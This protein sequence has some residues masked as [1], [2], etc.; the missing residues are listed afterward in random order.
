MLKSPMMDIDELTRV[1]AACRNV[2]AVAIGDHAIFT[3]CAAQGFQRVSAPSRPV[4]PYLFHG[5]AVGGG[6]VRVI[7]INSGSPT[8]AGGSGSGPTPWPALAFAQ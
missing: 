5:R 2:T 3:L 6:R 7:R 4:S 1:L 8:G